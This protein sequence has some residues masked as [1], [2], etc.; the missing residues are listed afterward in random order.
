MVQSEFEPCLNKDFTIG[1]FVFTAN[2]VNSIK[3]LSGTYTEQIT[4]PQ[5]HTVTAGVSGTWQLTATS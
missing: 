5:D 2:V 1:N 4:N 3:S